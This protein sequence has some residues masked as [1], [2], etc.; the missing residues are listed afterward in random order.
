MPYIAKLACPG[1]ND[2]DGVIIGQ[3]TTQ[4]T[5]QRGHA[6]PV[7]PVA[8]RQELDIVSTAVRLHHLERRSL[9]VGV[10]EHHRPTLIPPPEIIRQID[11]Q[12]AFA[13]AALYI[14]YKNSFTNIHDLTTPVRH[15]PVRHAD[16]LCSRPSKRLSITA[17]YLFLQKNNI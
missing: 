7:I 6:D 5:I 17:I 2:G 4:H 3:H 16:Q 1:I 13:N 12:G 8:D 11:S 14:A 10:E 15:T 9:R